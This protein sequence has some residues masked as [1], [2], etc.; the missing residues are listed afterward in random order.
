MEFIKGKWYKRTDLSFDECSDLYKYYFRCFGNNTSDNS[1]ISDYQI[2][3]GG[4]LIK[5]E[6]A[7]CND[8]IEINI[9]EIKHLLPKDYKFEQETK[10]YFY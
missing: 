4:K 8:K 2:T 9:S 7:S 3:K 6:F 1:F 5:D 10:Y